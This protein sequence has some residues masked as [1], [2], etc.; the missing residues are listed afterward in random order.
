MKKIAFA[1]IILLFSC[2]GGKKSPDV[3]HIQVDL[4]VQRFEKDLF[5]SDTMHLSESLTQLSQKYP[6]FYPIFINYMLGLPIKEIPQS[7]SMELKAI[8]QFIKDYAP[9]KSAS[10]KLFGDFKTQVDQIINGFKL[11]KYYYPDYPLPKSLITFI[12][13]LDANF[14]TS[15][16][17]QGDILLENSAAIGL[18][19]H[20]GKDFALYQSTEGQALYPNYLSANFDPAHIPVNVMH[21]IVDDIYP[22]TFTG[23]LVE[24]MVHNGRKLYL[25]EQF[26]PEV[27]E[28]IVLGYNPTQYKEAMENEALIWDFFLK[29]DLLNESDQHLI[30]SYIM[31][32][33]NTPE[34]GPKSPGNIGTFAG[35]QIVKKYMEKFPK[36]SLPEL[37]KMKEREIYSQSKYKP[38]L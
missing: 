5:E 26:L 29:N 28:S 31:D 32:G 22:E 21:N 16:G 34:L 7:G 19:L 6:V 10:D 33:P 35:L 27:D 8:Q 38:R 37:M 36:T 11:V 4:S 14:K 25:I 13:P 17:I 3:S 12:A 23:P 30:K 18:Q 15:F 24:Q 2:N 20:M 9:V 1:L